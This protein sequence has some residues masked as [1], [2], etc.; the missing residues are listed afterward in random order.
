M[1][2]KKD[3]L[4]ER[5]SDREP[6]D[7][8]SKD[9]LFDELEKA[10]AERVL[11]AELDEHLES[12]AAAGKSNHRNGYS[13]KTVLTETSKIDIKVP[14]DREGSFDPKLL[15]RR[16]PRAGGATGSRSSRFSPF[17]RRCGESS[18]PRTLLNL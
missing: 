4:D 13:K 16:S 7:V 12:E 2:I 9:G 3:T 18:T 8:Y 10:L 14:R 6:D 15:A 5:L 11:N 17:P 1:A